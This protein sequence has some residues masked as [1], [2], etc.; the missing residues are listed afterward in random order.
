MKYHRLAHLETVTVSKGDKVKRG[1]K[2]GTLGKSGD[3][4]YSPHL[5]WDVSNRPLKN[6]WTEYISN[7][8]KTDV[9]NVYIEPDHYLS[10]Y[11]PTR[12]DDYKKMKLDQTHNGYWWLSWIGYGY[13]PGYDLNYGYGSQDKGQD[14]LSP[15]DGEIEFIY[16]GDKDNG[17]WGRLVIIKETKMEFKEVL[18][19]I[20]HKIGFD[21]GESINENEAEKLVKKIDQ[22][23]KDLKDLDD[24]CQEQVNFIKEKNELIN[25]LDKKIDLLETTV[26][27]QK[28]TIDDLEKT[29]EPPIH[30]FKLFGFIFKLYK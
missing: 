4:D 22:I 30:Q 11:I 29:I 2:I 3:P 8:S 5:H 1:D 14:V 16:K 10:D 20:A 18:E 28:E 24:L 15:V 27:V 9:Q 12:N 6:N 17:G 7:W 25:E 19:E 13:H 26:D 23:M 21:Y